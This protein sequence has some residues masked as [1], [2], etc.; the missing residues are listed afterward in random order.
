MS[1]FY[2]TAQGGHGHAVRAGTKKTGLTVNAG[3]PDGAIRVSLWHTTMAPGPARVADHFM[4]SHVP[5]R[6][7]AG[8][9]RVICTG[10]I[11][12]PDQDNMKDK[13]ALL[14]IRELAE[15][16]ADDIDV[17]RG[18]LETIRALCA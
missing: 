12:D 11:G 2:G 6:E 13:T 1:H 14:E 7:D 4:I 9:N 15:E 16:D 5:N 8:T 10:V 3:G 17:L 18:I